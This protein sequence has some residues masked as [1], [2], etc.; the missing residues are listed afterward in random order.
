MNQRIEIKSG[1][2]LYAR[3]K[4]LIP[5]GTQLLSKRPE[6]F[7]PE[8]WPSYY[9]KALGA[10]IW[11]LDGNKYLDMSYNGIGACI[12]GHADP[13]VN[14]AVHTAVD[15]GSVSTLNCP[16]EVWLAERLIALHPWSEMVRFARTGGE[17]NAIAIAEVPYF[18]VSLGDGTS[19]V[20]W[21]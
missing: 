11:D 10:E 16:E 8:H 18:G 13:D 6:M 12:L 2:Q 19:S 5:G 4:K 9:S 14:A 17:A 21:Q 1:L 3:A 20:P 15:S 7:L